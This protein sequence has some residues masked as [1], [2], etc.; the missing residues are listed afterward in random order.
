MPAVEGLREKMRAHSLQ[1]K[2]STSHSITVRKQS[3]VSARALRTDSRNAQMLLLKPTGRFPVGVQDL[4]YC[5]AESPSSI[6]ADNVSKG[7]R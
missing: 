3:S 1:V 7:L 2:A 4:K 6:A 5:T